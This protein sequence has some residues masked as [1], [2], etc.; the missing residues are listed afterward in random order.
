MRFHT[1]FL[2]HIISQFTDPTSTSINRNSYELKITSPPD[3]SSVNGP[4]S[5][6]VEFI[7][8]L[9]N[10]NFD[11]AISSFEIILD[12]QS[13]LQVPLVNKSWSY[14]IV[15]FHGLER[16]LHVIEA[17]AFQEDA[18][19]P[20]SENWMAQSNSI[21]DRV[22]YFSEGT[23]QAPIPVSQHFSEEFRVFLRKRVQTTELGVQ[24]WPCNPRANGSSTSINHSEVWHANQTAIL[25]LD[26]WAVHG[27]KSASLR[28]SAM[29]SRMNEVL[30]EARNR[31]AMVIFCPSSGV[32]E[33]TPAY[34]VQRRRMA[35]AAT[36]CADPQTCRAAGVSHAGQGVD[37]DPRLE[38]P[39][40][41]A[42]G[43]DGGEERPWDDAT[44][45]QHPG[46]AVFPTDGLSDSAQEIVGFLRASGRRRVVLMGVHANECL[47]KRPFGLR[48]LPAEDG[49][50][51]AVV[52]DLVDVLHDP[53]RGPPISHA[54]AR[55]LVLRHIEAYLAPTLH[56]SDLTR[57]LAD[58]VD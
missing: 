24:S 9:V 27:C 56:S 25:V 1:L 7:N 42:G 8:R 54:R 20:G 41:I 29:V 39:L 3:G 57:S 17:V 35:E 6:K 53:R 26:M 44:H 48:R 55:A 37:A 11:H 46:L 38:P 5:V 43:C 31:G 22:H 10:S 50:T 28:L 18:D 4:F 2:F 30:M 21:T 12:G 40:P 14:Y 19:I 49:V 52:R 58:D 45:A 16:G 32:E 33:M 13:S 34:P 36:Q 15:N 23:V 47:L 51:V